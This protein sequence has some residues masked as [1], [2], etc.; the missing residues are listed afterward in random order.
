MERTFKIKWF[1]TLDS[2]NS[3]AEREIKTLK[4]HDVIAAQFQTTGRGQHGNS[5]SSDKDV[6]ATFSIIFKPKDY[7][8][9]K[10]F[11]YLEVCALGLCDYLSTK[12][13]SSKIKW[14]N[15]IY[16]GDYKICGTLISTFIENDRMAGMII[17]I[18]FNINQ[19][20]FSQD[21]PNPISLSLLTGKTYDVAAELEQILM[22][23]GKY[24][25]ELEGDGQVSGEDRVKWEYIDRLYRL[26]E[27]R[28]FIE[29]PS[30]NKVMGTILGVNTPGQLVIRLVDG[31]LRTYSFKEI[32]YV[33]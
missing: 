14:P 17:G 12:G 7:H 25:D 27:V 21:L 26:G 6:N 1:D 23:I 4:D 9:T 2:T 33:L 8:A 5:W 13:I 28:T 16:V 32:H 10:Q 15:D 20:H 18:G 31:G 3:Y 22:S 30:D 11:S 24:R 19:R 29:T